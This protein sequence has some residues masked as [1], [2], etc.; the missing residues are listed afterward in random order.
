M[1]MRTWLVLALMVSACGK[2]DD[3]KAPAKEPAP[4]PPPKAEP[5]PPPEPQP[6]A[7]APKTVTLD[8]L[9]MQIEVPG[10]WTLK[11]IKDGTYTFR[12]P[13]P[14]GTNIPPRLDVVRLAKGPKNVDA[15]AK[16][17]PAKVIEKKTL[18]DGRYY[19]IC[20]QTAAGRT[21]RNFQ[22]VTPEPE[23][24]AVTCSGNAA[25]VSAL[26]AACETLRKP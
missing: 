5:T 7:D 17:C 14:A 9:G 10:T 2:E 3:K 26:L 21:L 18:D 24:A 25:D 16:G 1:K 11:K 22:L 15:A 12:V 4:A 8:D 20:E 6:P 23:G 19:Y 13:Y